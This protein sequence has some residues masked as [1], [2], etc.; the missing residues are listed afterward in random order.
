MFWQGAQLCWRL[1]SWKCVHNREVKG[2]L[3]TI[4][5]QFQVMWRDWAWYVLLISVFWVAGCILGIILTVNEAESTSYFRIATLMGG[6]VGGVVGILT[7]IMQIRIYF[8]LEV[9][10]GCTRARF[11]VSFYIVNAVLNVMIVLFLLVLGVAEGQIY[12]RM[13]PG[14]GEEMDITAWIWRLGI[15]AAFVMPAVGGLSGG[16]VMRFGQKAFWVQWAVWMILCIGG[17]RVIDAAED[18][19][20]TVF[21]VIGRGAFRLFRAVPV[22]GWILAG[23]GL[24]LVC[25]AGTWLILRKQQVKG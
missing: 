21:G 25:L 22:N 17:P 23:T 3:Q 4:K 1:E 12:T 16:L 5:K 13:F 7:A 20:Q 11:F 8:D 14:L 18:A 15:P 9:A 24:G 19:P 6:M 2:M 10:A